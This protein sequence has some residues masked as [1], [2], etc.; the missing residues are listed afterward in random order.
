MKRKEIEKE[1]RETFLGLD[2]TGYYFID[3][4]VTAVN[5]LKILQC[6]LFFRNFP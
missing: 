6:L 5:T 3:K 2:V 1:V 4:R